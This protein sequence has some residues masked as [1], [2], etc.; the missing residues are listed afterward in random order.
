MEKYRRSQLAKHIIGG[1]AF[2]PLQDILPKIPYEQLGIIPKGL[3]YSLWQQVYHIY[4]VQHD[5]L[6]FS[7]N[8][9]YVAPNWPDDYWPKMPAPSDLEEW[10][11][12]IKLF[13]QEREEFI[14]LIQ[15]PSIKLYQ[16]LPHGN[17]QTLLR[18]ALLMIEHTAYHTGELLVIMRILDIY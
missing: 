15:D 12:T 14:Q 2:T 13:F 16:P 11:E 17:G 4:A 6:D 5:L 8:P 1:E 9:G 7:K 3:P 18:E 10:H